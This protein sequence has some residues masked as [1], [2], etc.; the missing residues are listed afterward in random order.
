MSDLGTPDEYKYYV[1]DGNLGTTGLLRIH[2]THNA[3]RPSKANPN[4]TVSVTDIDVVFAVWQENRSYVGVNAGVLDT[5]PGDGTVVRL[6]VEASWPA[7]INYSE[8]KKL[9]FVTE[10]KP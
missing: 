4:K 1:K 3:R 9:T 10:V 6:T 7:S 5:I 2:R 8:R